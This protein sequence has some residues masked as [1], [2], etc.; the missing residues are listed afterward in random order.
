MMDSAVVSC[1][2]VL[3]E[4][5]AAWAEALGGPGGVPLGFEEVQDVVLFH[6][7][8][9]AAELLPVVFGDSAVRRWAAPPTTELRLSAERYDDVGVAPALSA[10][11]DFARLGPGGHGSRQEMVVTISAEPS[12]RRAEPQDVMRR[13]V[14]HMAQAFGY[15][16]PR[17][18]CCSGGSGIGWELAG[19][20]VSAAGGRH[21]DSVVVLVVL[22]STVA[23]GGGMRM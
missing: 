3:V 2:D 19:V 16:M 1:V 6:T 4:D 15:C 10:F 9:T 21:R 17:R 22:A 20:A 8:A 7:W 23:C 5:A 18:G 12:M 11:V 13:A 14:V